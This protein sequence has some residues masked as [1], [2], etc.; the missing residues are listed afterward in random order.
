MSIVLLINHYTKFLKLELEQLTGKYLVD[1]RPTPT[2]DI[3]FDRNIRKRLWEKTEEII[4]M[5]FD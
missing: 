4:G 5:R 2:K 1:N 3:T